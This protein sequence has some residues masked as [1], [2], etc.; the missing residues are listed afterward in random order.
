MIYKKKF[1][2]SNASSIALLHTRKDQS[3]E[4]SDALRQQMQAERVDPQMLQELVRMLFQYDVLTSTDQPVLICWFVGSAAL[5]M[6]SLSTQLIGQLCHE[7]LCSYLNIDQQK[8]QPVH[9]LRCRICGLKNHFVLCLY[10]G[11]PGMVINTFEDRIHFIQFVL[12]DKMENN[13]EHLM[14]LMGYDIQS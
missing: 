4:M 6:E 3:F 14:H 5:L 9:V 12:P 13:Y 1:W 7:V 2:R 10:L 11:V 8:Y